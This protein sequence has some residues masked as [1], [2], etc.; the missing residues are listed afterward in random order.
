MLAFYF[1]VCLN[2]VMKTANDIIDSLGGTSATARLCEVDP[3]AVSQWRTDGIP[4]ARLMYLKLA[5]PKE[6]GVTNNT[7]K[8]TK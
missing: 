7:Q 6:C 5:Y 1:E 2:S 8:A 3:A 4:K